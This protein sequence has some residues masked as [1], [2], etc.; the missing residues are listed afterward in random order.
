VVFVWGHSQ[1]FGETQ[2]SLALYSLKADAR[3]VDAVS[4]VIYSGAY[5]MHQG[6]AVSL[7]GD[8]D[9]HMVHLVHISERKGDRE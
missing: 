6:L 5:L 4:G 2:L 9:S 8:F 7:V 3:Y 1:Q